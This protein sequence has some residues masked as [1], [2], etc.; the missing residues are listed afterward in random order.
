MDGN[1]RIPGGSGLNSARACGWSFK[2]SGFAGKVAYIGCIGD[3]KRGEVLKESVGPCGVLGA[4]EVNQTAETGACAVIVDGK[5]RALCAYLG[6]SCKY[7]LDHLNAN[8]AYLHA[9]KFIYATG[10]FITSNAQALR[11]IATFASEHDKIFAFSLSAVF[12]IKFSWDEVKNAV[13]HADYVVCNADEC[14][15]FGEMIG[16]EGK[17]REEVARRIALLPKQNTKRNRIVIVTAG[18]DPIIVA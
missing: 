16:V 6:A 11:Q 12:I 3:D 14:D 1:L 7:S 9:A 8:L 18:I 2:K 15:A 13:E 5:E 17:D 4:F 10:F